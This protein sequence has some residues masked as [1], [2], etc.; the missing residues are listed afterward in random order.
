MIAPVISDILAADAAIS[1]YCTGVYTDNA[2]IGAACPYIVV[3]ADDS[4]ET[5]DVIAVFEIRI[6]VYDYEENK[7]PMHRISKRIKDILNFGVFEAEGSGYSRVR[8][9]FEN[10]QVFLES[11]STLGR[12]HLRFGARALEDIDTEN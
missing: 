3:A 7:R 11:D 6:D 12:V 5:D 4:T 2:P 1:A 8:V 9:W 10:R